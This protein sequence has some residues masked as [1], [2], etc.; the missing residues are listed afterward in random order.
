MGCQDK[1][2]KWARCL[3]EAASPECVNMLLY[4]V[5]FSAPQS[6]HLESEE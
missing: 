2:I 1:G 3:R 5:G 4:F 6:R